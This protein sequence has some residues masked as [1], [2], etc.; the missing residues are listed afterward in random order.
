[1]FIELVESLACL[2][3]HQVVLNLTLNFRLAD[4]KLTFRF[5]RYCYLDLSFTLLIY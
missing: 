1:M 5:W 3:L 2:D 4:M